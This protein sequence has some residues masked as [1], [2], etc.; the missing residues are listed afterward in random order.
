MAG[1]PSIIHRKERAISV[2][3]QDEFAKVNLNPVHAKSNAE[4]GKIADKGDE[5][6]IEWDAMAKKYEE[7]ETRMAEQFE[8]DQG[9]KEDGPPIIK[10]PDKP[11]KEQW[12]RHQTIHTP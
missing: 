4:E 3:P 9:N 8:K 5:G 10:V 12:E 7:L 1:D 2:R 11:T 6:Q